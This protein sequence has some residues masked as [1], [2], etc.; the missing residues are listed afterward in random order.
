MIEYKEIDGRKVGI[1]YI[2]DDHELVEKDQA[3]LMKM[4]FEDGDVS[5]VEVNG[6]PKL[7]DDPG[8]VEDN[9]VS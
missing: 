3:T 1:A 2:N 7:E 5:Y 4:T 9:D 6:G 8:E